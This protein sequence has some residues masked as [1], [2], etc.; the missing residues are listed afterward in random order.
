MYAI[1]TSNL[2]YRFVR[3][4]CNAYVDVKI[5]YS[6]TMLRKIL[7]DV[8]LRGVGT[9]IE[10]FLFIPLLLMIILRLIFNVFQ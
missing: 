3:N 6:T 5:N 9:C 4:F 7:I 10:L 8:P 1:G 2:H